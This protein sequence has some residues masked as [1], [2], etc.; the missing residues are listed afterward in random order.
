V[1]A[2]AEASVHLCSGRPSLLLP[3]AQRGHTVTGQWV[4]LIPLSLQPAGWHLL[5]LIDVATPGVMALVKSSQEASRRVSAD[6]IPS[7]VIP[8][9]L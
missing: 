8:T 2:P 9:T 7:C 3:R 5:T 4:V 1:S 6:F